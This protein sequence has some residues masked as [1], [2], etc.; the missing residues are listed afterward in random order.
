MAVKPPPS[1]VNDFINKG[2]PVKADIQVTDE[3][4]LISLRMPRSFL[5]EIDNILK[6]RIGLSRNALILE[7][8][9]EKI[10]RSKNDN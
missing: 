6:N 9:Q 10:K 5:N 1:K 7:A 4:I 2:A 8:L 3:C